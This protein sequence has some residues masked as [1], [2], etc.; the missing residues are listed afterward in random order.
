[1]HDSANHTNSALGNIGGHVN[2]LV[3]NASQVENWDPQ[4]TGFNGRNTGPL[5][6]LDLDLL[7]NN[8]CLYQIHLL[9]HQY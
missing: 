8:K 5:V 6:L 3:R 1:M 2:R 9:K 4:T 7:Y